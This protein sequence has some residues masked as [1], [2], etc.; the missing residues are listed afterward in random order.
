M[1]IGTVIV[2]GAFNIDFVLRAALPNRPL[3]NAAAF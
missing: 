1:A 2:G 3:T